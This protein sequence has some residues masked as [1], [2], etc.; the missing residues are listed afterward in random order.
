MKFPQWFE[1]TLKHSLQVKEEV[2]VP[3]P[4]YYT[5]RSAM[6]GRPLRVS[7][8]AYSSCG[9]TAMIHLLGDSQGASFEWALELERAPE[10]D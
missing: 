2:S 4:F 10:Q 7:E 8:V 6:F 5:E 1:D 3:F 9:N